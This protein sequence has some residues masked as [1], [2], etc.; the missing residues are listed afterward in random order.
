MEMLNVQ[1]DDIA[2]VVNSSRPAAAPRTVVQTFLETDLSLGVERGSILCRT[3]AE[4]ILP[5]RESVIGSH[6]RFPIFPRKVKT[7]LSRK[8]RIPW[9]VV[10]SS[11]LSFSRP[12]DSVRP[13]WTPARVH[14]NVKTFSLSVKSCFP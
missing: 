13:K 5:M 4:R 14:T 3:D 9:T 2:G 1:S 7:K 8:S 6:C 10:T 12:H 11:M